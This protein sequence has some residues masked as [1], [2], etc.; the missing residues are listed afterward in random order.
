MQ[1][2]KLRQVNR[3][4]AIAVIQPAQPQAATGSIRKRR[5]CQHYSENDARDIDHITGTTL[6]CVHTLPH[7]QQKTCSCC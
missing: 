4:V 3:S 6:E 1:R 2:L 5:S 7:V